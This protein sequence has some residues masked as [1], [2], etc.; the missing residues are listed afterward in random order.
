MVKDDDRFT[1]DFITTELAR[2]KV[3]QQEGPSA[4][5]VRAAKGGFEHLSFAELA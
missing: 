1:D 5:R 3:V 2:Q 4:N